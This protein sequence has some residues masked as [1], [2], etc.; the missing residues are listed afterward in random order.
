[1]ILRIILL[2]KCFLFLFEVTYK[3]FNKQPVVFFLLS[4]DL[5]RR[6]SKLFVRV[7]NLFQSLDFLHIDAVL[8]VLNPV[9]GILLSSSLFPLLLS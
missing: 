9:K 3:T 7:S 4:H 6:E 1:M 8:L 5:L 2:H